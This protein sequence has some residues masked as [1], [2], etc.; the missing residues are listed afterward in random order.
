MP[1]RLSGVRR[2]D[3]IGA[4]GSVSSYN[5]KVLVGNYYEERLLADER[6][7]AKPVPVKLESTYGTSFSDPAVRAAGASLAPP[8]LLKAPDAGQNLL[9]G[10]AHQASSGGA[11]AGRRAVQS[12]CPVAVA[13]MPAKTVDALQ[14]K[15]MQWKQE[16]DPDFSRAGVPPMHEVVKQPVRVKAPHFVH[17]F[18]EDPTLLGLRSQ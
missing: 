12:K 18:S 9:L 1:A 16:R 17:S 10:Q 14:R 13:G 3:T 4:S 7:Q 5:H 11:T 2:Q 6:T 15:Q 8:P